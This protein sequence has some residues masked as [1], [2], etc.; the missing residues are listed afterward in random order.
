MESDLIL[1]GVTS[2]RGRS[3][4]SGQNSPL[5]RIIIII[6]LLLFVPGSLVSHSVISRVTVTGN[7]HVNPASD[8]PVPWNS[9]HLLNTWICSALI[10]ITDLTGFGFL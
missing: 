9:A 5:K 10:S 2:Q 3:W 8:W 1:S 7:N 6:L 4:H